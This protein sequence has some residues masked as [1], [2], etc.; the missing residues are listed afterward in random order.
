MTNRTP[1]PRRP[2]SGPV[3]ASVAVH[4][5]MVALGWW[6]AA[7]TAE[8]PFEYVA[9]EMQL[10]TMAQPDPPEEL[11]APETPV[12]E[13]PEDTPPVEEPEPEPAIPEEPEPEPDPEPE[14][15]PEPDPPAETPTEVAETPPE[16][17]TETASSEEMAVRMEGLR[18]DFPAYYQQIVTEISRCFRW[19]DGGNWT[20][21][22]RFEITRDGRIP[23]STI[24]VHS[25]SG[26]GAF[27]ITAFGAVEC[28]GA[29][30]LDPLPEE[31][32]YDQLP[33]QFTFSPAG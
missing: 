25:R 8:E 12:V 6:S 11:V 29:G 21:V 3:L 9:Y 27:D 26:S 19:I 10:V 15:E 1:N 4:A 16:D 17:V 20:T 30:R 18:R 31:M 2:G 33:I 7:R 28:A 14:E 24:R 5:A 13:T 22:L 32:P 23:N